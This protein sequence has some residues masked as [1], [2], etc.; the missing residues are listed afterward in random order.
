MDASGRSAVSEI[1]IINDGS[2]DNTKELLANSNIRSINN[3]YSKGNGA[4]IKSGARAAKNNFLVFMDADG[5]HN[6]DDILPL[7]NKLLEGYDMVLAAI[8]LKP[9]FFAHLQIICTTGL[10]A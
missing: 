9:A 3:P 10:P 7:V 2:N 8:I 1:I 6:P 5:Q 4:A